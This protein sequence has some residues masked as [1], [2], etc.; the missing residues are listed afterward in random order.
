VHESAFA[1]D[2]GHP[3]MRAL[4]VSLHCVSKKGRF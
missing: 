2:D 4:P 1:A 3:R